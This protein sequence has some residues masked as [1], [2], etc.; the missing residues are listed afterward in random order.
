MTYSESLKSQNIE[1]KLR[2]GEDSSKFIELKWFSSE[3]RFENGIDIFRKSEN[4]QEWQKI[5]SKPI[6]PDLKV[7]LP[8]E[9]KELR[10]MV[11]NIEYSELKENLVLL[12]ILTQAIESNTFARSIG[13]FYRDTDISENKKYEYKILD[14]STGDLLSISGSIDYESLIIR[15]PITEL[16]WSGSS[17][18]SFLSWLPNEKEWYSYDVFFK[19]SSENN[20]IKHNTRP[21]LI[22]KKSDNIGRLVFEEIRYPIEFK[23]EDSLYV[24]VSGRNYFG[25]YTGF[26]DTL[27]LANNS[28]SIPMPL[29]EE[30]SIDSVQIKFIGTN[31]HEFDSLKILN[32]K[33]SEGPYDVIKS[34]VS[35]DTLFLDLKKVKSAENYFIIRG[36][37]SNGNYSD[38]DKKFSYIRDLE[39]PD[40]P[41][42]TYHTLTN[43]S[44]SIHW[45]K[46][47]VPDLLGYYIYHNVNSTDSSYFSLLNSKYTNDTS[48]YENI[49]N[50][51]FKSI[52]YKI[53]AID[54]FY[55]RSSYSSIYTATLPDNSRPLKPKIKSIEEQGDQIS[56]VLEKYYYDN[57]EGF[58][59]QVADA[60]SGSSFHTIDDLSFDKDKMEFRHHPKQPALLYRA[61]VKN[62]N[63][64]ISYS[65]SK[66]IKRTITEKEGDLKFDYRV[67]KSKKQTVI[68]VKQ[69]PNRL[70]GYIFF[71]S[72]NDTQLTGLQ[73]SPEKFVFPKRMNNP[74]YV[75]RLYYQN[76]SKITTIEL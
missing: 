67:K 23:T 68:V 62:P 2:A 54:K 43:D 71:D 50:S 21:L 65:N 29:I 69:I 36:I 51:N 6:R 14:G 73:K 53:V 40:A 56:I 59:L 30:I 27:L 74:Q 1:L 64:N 35:N 39:A 76:S 44:I 46:V 55:N 25:D 5:N 58:F 52:S 41:I 32:S 22:G 28:R 19:S 63:G 66:F 13:W 49:K 24:F 11:L 47:D 38:S 7:L 42:I 3:L 75:I 8:D 37:S 17:D 10:D 12:H 9:Y 57:I 70:K 48:F 15:K 18:S 26:S 31:F 72:I 4:Q 20:Y 60:D 33:T 34:S 45:S 61:A 16:K